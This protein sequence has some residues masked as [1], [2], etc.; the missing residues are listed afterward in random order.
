MPSVEI[1]V[2]KKLTQ[3]ELRGIKGF[4][5]FLAR[6][7]NINWFKPKETP[8]KSLLEQFVQQYFSCLNLPPLP[9]KLIEKNW[10]KAG[11]VRNGEL[12]VAWHAAGDK[13]WRVAWDTG[14]MA[15]RDSAGEMAR[16]AVCGAARNVPWT[17]RRVARGAE[18]DATR[19]AVQCARWIIVKDLMPQEGYN[20]G[21]PFEP[22]IEIYKLGC[23]PIGIVP[24]EKDEKEFVIFIPPSKIA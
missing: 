18:W 3:E 20:K 17:A 13:T 15:T 22:L 6:V 23:W 2:P 16:D 1:N 21:N 14:L 11:A 7:K 5:E 12:E 19:D 9:I 8:D 24:N 10:S 4:T